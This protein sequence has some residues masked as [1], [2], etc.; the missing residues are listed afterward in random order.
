MSQ[1]RKKFDQ[2]FKE[3]AVRL[4][5]ETGKPI[6]Q[7]AGSWVFTTGRWG[8]GS[9]LTGGA[10]SAVVVRCARMNGRSWCGC[11]STARSCRCCV[12]SSSA[13]WPF[14]FRRRWAG[15]RG[16]FHRCPEGRSRHSARHRAKPVDPLLGQ[17]IEAWQAL[18]EDIRTYEVVVTAPPRA[19]I[20]ATATVEMARL[21]VPYALT[22]VSSM[23]GKVVRAR[24]VWFGVTVGSIS[25]SLLEQEL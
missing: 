9:T 16:R 11:A 23:T 4:V 24:G 13:V 1:T 25:Y 7:V 5:R 10:V 3:G 12:M 8:I 19:K 6:A 18:Q 14:G 2:D 15:S 21:E 20:A 22:G 17:A